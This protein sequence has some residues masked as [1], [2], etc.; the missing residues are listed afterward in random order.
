MVPVYRGVSRFVS[1][2]F[3]LRVDPG[4]AERW[5]EATTESMMVYALCLG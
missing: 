4:S 1:F 5:W 2:L 3:S